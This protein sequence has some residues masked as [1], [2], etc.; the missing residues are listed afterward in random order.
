VL[1]SGAIVGNYEVDSVLGEGGMAL[2]YKVKHTQLGSLH[3]LKVLTLRKREVVERMLQEGRL[4]A[5][6]RHPNVVP[7]T[8]VLDIDGSPGL[9]M[10]FV[11][12][13]SLFE[14]LAEHRPTVDEAEE[15]F[16]GIVAGVAEAHARGLVHRD[17][18]PANVLMQKTATGVLPRVADFGL[19][20]VVESTADGPQ[21]RAGSTM[22]TPAYMAPEQVKDAKTV[23][24][25]ADVFSLGCILYD[26]VCGQQ[27]FDDD[28]L[29]TLMT[30]TREGDYPRPDTLITDLPPRIS[31]AIVR[32][33][34]PDR[35]KRLPSCVALLEAL[36]QDKVVAAAPVHKP[37]EPTSTELP[38]PVPLMAA[39]VIAGIGGIALVLGAAFMCFGVGVMSGGSAPPTDP[40][41]VIVVGGAPSSPSPT[42]TTMPHDDPCSAWTNGLL[43]YAQVRGIFMHTSGQT[44]TVI[45]DKKVRS[46]MPTKDNGFKSS[47]DVVCVLQTGDRVLLQEDPVRVRGSGWWVPV[48]GK[49]V[50][51]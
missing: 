47:T 3:A 14:W 37:S 27:A 6:L 28:D 44:W 51:W 16:R 26:L 2:V 22:G 24:Q 1:E 7:V 39:G 45:Q 17:L 25:R 15:L 19:A 20:K 4:Q 34:E 11:D 23:D 49:S 18:K 42:A 13:P 35:D 10:D 29:L 30:K 12:G 5:G 36:S 32:S 40:A 21:T 9:I 43:G 48:H 8:D 41:P 50:S 31:Q 38:V 46:E 33:L